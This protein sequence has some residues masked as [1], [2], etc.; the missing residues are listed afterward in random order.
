MTVI[1]K[2]INK[3]N[4][5][6]IQP[7]AKEIIIFKQVIIWIMLGI[8]LL[9]GALSAS[10]I[11]FLL[12]NTEWD[13]WHKIGMSNW[14]YVFLVLPYIWLIIFAAFIYLAQYN[15]RHTRTGYKISILKIIIIFLAATFF[16]GGIMY[17]FKVGQMIED[18]VADSFDSYYKFYGGRLIWDKPE[19]G[20]VG[21]QII[22]ILDDSH[23]ILKDQGGV[24]WQVKIMDLNN[25]D[26]YSVG[27]KIKIIGQVVGDNIFEATEIKSWCGCG[28]C[29]TNIRSGCGDGGDGICPMFGDGVSDKYNFERK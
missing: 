16:F 17:Q 13:L 12:A 20:M 19:M 3:I 2:V 28:G 14:Q 6:E 1:K 10:V 27:L 7:I 21:G 5:E 9:L 15:F 22:A 23:L 8:L 18:N 11:V 26:D 29:K 25:I 24:E 4:Q